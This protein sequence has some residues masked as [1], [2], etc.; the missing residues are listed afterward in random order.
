MFLMTL[1][2]KVANMSATCCHDSQML[3]H[4]AQMPLS[5]QHNFDPDPFSVSGFAD[6]LPFLLRVP[7]V[8]TA[9]SSVSSHMRVTVGGAK[10]YEYKLGPETVLSSF[11]NLRRNV[12]YF[13]D[14]VTQYYFAS[15]SALALCFPLTMMPSWYFIFFLHMWN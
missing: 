10:R 8:H 5:W 12:P 7:E 13:Y 11:L 9:N 3:A 2:D 6:N 4:F 14:T 15:V 1:A